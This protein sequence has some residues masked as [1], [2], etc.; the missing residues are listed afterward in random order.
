YFKFIVHT[1]APCYHTHVALVQDQ[2]ALLYA[3]YIEHVVIW[4]SYVK[5]KNERV[6]VSHHECI[7]TDELVVLNPFE[8]HFLIL[9]ILYLPFYGNL[10]VFVFRI[11][12][13][14]RALVAGQMHERKR[15]ESH[16]KYCLQNIH[17][18]F[19][20]DSSLLISSWLVTLGSAL[21]FDAFITS[22]MNI[23]SSPFLPLRYSLTLSG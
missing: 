5:L 16:Q 17:Y 15:Y 19:S 13:S 2:D 10:T 7:D 3:A 20:I 23:P 21:P 9:G 22:P 6:V 11:A 14:F 18:Y 12:V 4:L 1:R 8:Y